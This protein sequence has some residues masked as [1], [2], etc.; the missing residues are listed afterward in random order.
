MSFRQRLQTLNSFSQRERLLRSALGL[1]AQA[2][3]PLSSTFVKSQDS[4]WYTLEDVPADE[5]NQNQHNWHTE[6]WRA[7]AADTLARL[8][9]RT[10]Q[11]G[12][13]V[14]RRFDQHQNRKRFLNARALTYTSHYIHNTDDCAEIEGYF[15]LGDGHY[16]SLT[17]VAANGAAN[18]LQEAINNKD[19]MMVEQSG[20]I[21]FG[22]GRTKYVF[23]DVLTDE[24]VQQ[25]IAEWYVD[26][27]EFQRGHWTHLENRLPTFHTD[28]AW[29]SFTEQNLDAPDTEPSVATSE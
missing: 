19:E 9:T 14:R 4:D 15:D 13:T 10:V 27:M 1:P 20:Y 12:R 21:M 29:E 25:A 3:S 26:R 28:L 23:A 18:W 24:L 17:I 5:L 22:G 2:P 16:Y 8:P 11:A 7:D 6:D